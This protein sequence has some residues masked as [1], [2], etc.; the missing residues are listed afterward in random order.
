MVSVALYHP[1]IAAYLC[2]HP[3][4]VLFV[5]SDEAAAIR[6]L[7]QTYGPKGVRVVWQQHARRSNGTAPVHL[8][9]H[10]PRAGVMANAQQ[11]QG[12]RTTQRGSCEL[13]GSLA[14]DVLIDTM[15][16]ASCDFLIKATSFVSEVAIYLNPSLMNNSFDLGLRGHPPLPWPHC[17]S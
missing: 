14:H 8:C 1:L 15:A 10:A 12:R 11:E 16:L 2:A 17:T 9:D 5:A 3:G 4:S 7:A 13:S 6:E